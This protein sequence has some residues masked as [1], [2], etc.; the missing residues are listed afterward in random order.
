MVTI[1]WAFVG[2]VM[3]IVGGIGTV[4]W[5]A[6]MLHGRSKTVNLTPIAN[7]E[8]V[9]PVTAEPNAVFPRGADMAAPPGAVDWVHDVCAAMSMA[10]PGTVLE[11]LRGGESRDQARTRRI[12][13]LEEVITKGGGV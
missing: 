11:S 2:M 6:V 3:V 5:G 12:A 4:V 8:P 9:K 13:E 1:D 10:E 7:R